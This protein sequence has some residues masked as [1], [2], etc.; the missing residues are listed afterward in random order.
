MDRIACQHASF[1]WKGTWGMRL[2]VRRTGKRKSPVHA[3]WQML[4]S[5]IADVAAQLVQ[6][7]FLTSC[8]TGKQVPRHGRRPRWEFQWPEALLCSPCVFPPS[9]EP[10][11]RCGC[12]EKDKK[13][14]ARFRGRSQGICPGRAWSN[15]PFKDGSGFHAGMMESFHPTIARRMRPFLRRAA[16]C[17]TPGCARPEWGKAAYLPTDATNPGRQLRH[18]LGEK[19]PHRIE[20]DDSVHPLRRDPPEK[21]LHR[22]CPIPCIRQTMRRRPPAGVPIRRQRRM[23]FARLS[24]G[25]CRYPGRRPEKPPENNCILDE[26]T[27]GQAVH[28]FP[29]VQLLSTKVSSPSFPS[30][31][32]WSNPASCA[33]ARAT[34]KAKS[35]CSG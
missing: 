31:Q 29:L 20:C 28:D 33:M 23:Q 22:A 17:N 16:F 9:A 27:P 12:A 6:I 26:K 25:L 5:R 21:I 34:S 13:C 35:K 14:A 24:P 30:I 15:H 8:W 18:S 11:R 7:V 32:M 4:R 1:V 10:H 3:P 19:L 2:F